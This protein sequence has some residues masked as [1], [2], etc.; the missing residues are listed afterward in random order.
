MSFCS[1]TAPV[2]LQPILSRLDALSA[3]QDAHR[4]LLVIDGPCGSGKTTLATQ[5]TDFLN[6][7]APDTA[8][9]LH[10]DDFFLPHALKTPERLAI[11][12]GNVDLERLCTEV[13]MPFATQQPIAYRRYLCH[14]DAFSPVISVPDSPWLILEGSYSLLPEIR[15]HASLCVFLTVS[16]ACQQERLLQRVG[17]E[18]LEV[19]NRRW[20]PLENAYFKAYHLPDS[21][22]LMLFS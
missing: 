5:L 18:R 11:P 9:L 4:R 10:M 14:E 13:L 12:G 21:D 3:T 6:T 1:P 17:A 2:K 20:I 7:C 8:A 22:C 19:F 15:Q 16:S